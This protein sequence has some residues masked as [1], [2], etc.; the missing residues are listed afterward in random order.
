MTF[1]RAAVESS[2]VGILAFEDSGSIT[3]VN[4]R[5]CS[6]G[7]KANTLIGGSS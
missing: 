1:F 6:I 3:F 4:Q 7:H 5:I 2:P